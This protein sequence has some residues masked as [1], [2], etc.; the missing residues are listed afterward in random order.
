[1]P[2]TVAQDLGE[3]FS[4]LRFMDAIGASMHDE[5]IVIRNPATGASKA[6]DPRI[7]L[8]GRSDSCLRQAAR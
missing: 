7:Q 6:F 4:D 8:C 5:T 3:A 2:D 1:M